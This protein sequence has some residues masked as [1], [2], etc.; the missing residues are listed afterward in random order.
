MGSLCLFFILI[1]L[2]CASVVLST[3]WCNVTSPL[4]PVPANALYFNTKSRYEEV[5]PYLISNISAINDSWVKPPYPECKAVHLSVIARHGTRYPTS[6]NI[7][8]MIQ[9]SKLVKSQADLSCVRE[10]E[11]WKMWYKEDMDG[12]LVEKG[13]SDHRHLAQRLVKS[14]PTLFTKENLETRRVKFLTSSKHRCINSTLAFKHG[15]VEALRVPGMDLQ[16]T[17]NDELMRFF[18]RCQRLVETVEKNK[19]AVKEVT[20]FNNGPEMK[21]VQEKL[22]DRLQLPYINVTSDSV[23]TVF[24]L[25]AYEFTIHGVNSPWCRLLDDADAR[26]LEYSG[27]LKQFWKRGFGHEINSK[28]SC[29]LFHDLFNRLDAVA[30]NITSG[31]YVS[32]VVMV[33]VGHA[34]TLLPLLTLL[35]LFKDKVPLNSTNFS[36]HRSRAFR[37]GVIV[38]Y[39][40]NLVMALFD[41]PDGI[42]VQ[43]RLNEQPLSLPGLNNLSPL[44]Q[45]LRKRYEQLLQGCDQNTVCKMNS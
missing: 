7:K 10:L 18:D 43:A 11:T 29:V 1:H 38:P 42:R 41:C 24:Y 32:D 9:F 6:G 12:R 36:S 14:F 20:L 34:E 17:V 15:V 31:G 19:D 27:D 33:Q 40:A 21:R 16:H 35:D 44:Y 25:C 8:K 13:R 37:S 39:A 23:E 30:R 22:A 28:S 5:N 4:G 45:D 2:H 3:S 26:V